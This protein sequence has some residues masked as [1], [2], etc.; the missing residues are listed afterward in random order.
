[1]TLKIKGIKVSKSK[2][3]HRLPRLMVVYQAHKVQLLN[4]S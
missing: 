3:H 2:A 1:M 4:L